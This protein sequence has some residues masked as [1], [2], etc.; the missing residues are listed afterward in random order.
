MRRIFLIIII[1][2]SVIARRA[3]A[4]PRIISLAPNTTEILFSIG[5]G[6]SIVGTDDFSNYPE[7]AKGIER[8]GTFNNPNI[9]RIILLNPDYILVNSGLE[10]SM[11]DYLTSLGMKVIKISP[12]T[13]E[14]LYSD[15]RKLG[16][17]FNKEEDARKIIQNMQSRIRNLSRTI[18]GRPPKVFVQ[19]FD[20]PLVTVS[21]FISDI[22]A[23]AGGENIALDM[24]NDS[25]I[26]SYEALI[27]RNPD[28][29][30]IVGFSGNAGNFNSINAVKNKR[31]YKDLDPDLIL[32]PG[33]RAVEA[34][35]A[36][37]KVFYE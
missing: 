24:K 32:R 29:I 8:L 6:D 15:I 5:L 3:E 33:P 7:E 20:D 37:N 27:N 22:I 35:E 31:I 25:G 16:A 18:K 2:L 11:E 10:K 28:I 17:V 26:F 12:K 4:A 1:L 14:D 21:S 23:L 9:E 34:V 19:L 36:L 13:I 30:L